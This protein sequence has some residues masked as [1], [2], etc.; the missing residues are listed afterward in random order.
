MTQLE[1]LKE[2]ICI[3]IDLVDMISLKRVAAKL[4]RLLDEKQPV[5]WRVSAYNPE[6]PK[7][8]EFH[9]YEF[10]AE[11]WEMATRIFSGL[12][13]QYGCPGDFDYDLELVEGSVIDEN[14]QE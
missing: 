5:L 6:D 10:E 8:S 9:G 4:I 13:G 3:E 7:R 2:K 1:I 12:A 14:L 11:S